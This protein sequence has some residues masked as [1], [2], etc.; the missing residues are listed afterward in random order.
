MRPRVLKLGTR[1]SALARAQSAGV[2]RELERLHAGL[3]VELVGIETRGDRIQDRPLSSVDG[4]EFFTAEIDAALLAGTVDFTVHSYKDLSLERPTQLT[5]AAVPQRQ[6]P[7]DIVVFAADVAERLA[8]GF[9]VVIGSSSPRRLSFVPE[10]LKRLLP[11]TTAGEAARIRMVELRGNVDS[12]LRRLHEPRGS[13]RALDGIVLAFAGLARLWADEAGRALLERLFSPL[14]RMVLPLS[15]C[16]AAPA[17]GALGIECRAHDGTSAQ[18]LAAMDHAATRRA[19]DAE[20]AVLAERGGGCHQRL[21]ATQIEV[22]ELGTLLYLREDPGEPQLRWTPAV[23]LPAPASSVRAWDGSRAARGAIEPIEAGIALSLARLP[24]TP[25]LFVAHVRALPD[26]VLGIINPAAH[27]WVPG[28]STWQALAE[29]GLWVEGCADGL[30]VA[31]LE[32]LLQEPLLQLPP[33]SHW[34]VLTHA[35]AAEGWSAG[36]AI[37]SYRHRDTG[38]AAAQAGDAPAHDAS[39][40][41]WHSS[42]QFDRWA[43]RVAGQAQH[44]CAPGKT[45]QHLRRAQVQNLRMFPSAVQWRAWLGL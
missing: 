23:P 40:V 34:P 31:L 18:W 30:G 20:R 25:A 27:I 10:L 21:G 13:A 28:L 9:E 8:G 38:D 3:T 41:Y 14:P 12:R 6:Q 22:P 37:A 45:Y 7:H 39:H 35:A 15:A 26:Q 43:G 17:Q 36:Q 32:P 24:A 5:L 11:R 42:A 2:A 4:K 44:A 33:L 29:R 16:P 1:R 19:V